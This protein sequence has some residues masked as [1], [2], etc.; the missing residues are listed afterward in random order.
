MIDTIVFD[1]GGVIEKVYPSNVIAA[2]NGLCIKNAERFYSLYGQSDIC[3]QLEKGTIGENEF[4]SYINSLSDIQLSTSQINKAWCMNQGGVDIE[5]VN[6]LINLRKSYK[7][8]I[9]SNTNIIHYQ[10]ILR[11]FREKYHIDFKYLFDGIFLSFELGL[12]KPDHRIFEF[13]FNQVS[14]SKDSI[15][16]VDDLKLNCEA[17]SN[18]GVHTY[19][20]KTNTVLDIDLFLKEV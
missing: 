20:H 13:V 11:S 2:F 14:S 12:R 7:L 5:V 19:L 16:Y 8:Y 9:L 6:Y 17:A 1:L 10:Y 18:Y 15:V 3:D 4:S